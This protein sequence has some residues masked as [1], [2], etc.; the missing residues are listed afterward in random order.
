MMRLDGLG[1]S[2]G[3]GA[4]GPQCPFHFVS[5]RLRQLLTSGLWWWCPTLAVSLMTLISI[6][7]HA[8]PNRPPQLSV[9][10]F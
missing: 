4:N 6:V 8:S 7:I 2:G 3:L 10:P 1:E 5:S 9:H